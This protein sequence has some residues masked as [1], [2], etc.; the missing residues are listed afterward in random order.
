[1][2]FSVTVTVTAEQVIEVDA[3][4]EFQAMGEARHFFC[5]ERANIIDTEAV[6]EPLEDE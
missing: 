6:A 4:D 1:M 2:K 5:L 3:A